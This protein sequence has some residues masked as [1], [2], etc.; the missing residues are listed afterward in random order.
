MSADAA[1]PP[2]VGYNEEEDMKRQ[3]LEL[4]GDQRN[5]LRPPPSGVKFYFNFDSSF[6]VAMAILEEDKRVKEMRFKLVPKK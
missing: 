5:F 6:P 1:V 3:I 2:W 4:S